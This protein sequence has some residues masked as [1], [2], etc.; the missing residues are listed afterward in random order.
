MAKINKT[1]QDKAGRLIILIEV[2]DG[3]KSLEEAQRLELTLFRR[4]NLVAYDPML[5]LVVS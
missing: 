1:G 5:N 4:R 3:G 2:P